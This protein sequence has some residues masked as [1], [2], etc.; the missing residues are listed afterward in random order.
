MSV[1]LSILIIKRSL[2]LMDRYPNLSLPIAVIF[3]AF[4]Y[5]F[6]CYATWIT[7]NTIS[8]YSFGILALDSGSSEFQKPLT[9]QI[10]DILRSFSYVLHKPPTLEFFDPEWSQPGHGVFFYT[11]F[12]IYPTLGFYQSTQLNYHIILSYVSNLLRLILL[13]SFTFWL[14]L[15][16][17]QSATMRLWAR[18]VESE[19]P[20]FTVVFGGAAALAKA[21]ELAF[22]WL[23]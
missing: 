10:G 14:C 17:L 13:A 5:V 9:D 4:Q 20:V 8:G 1:S 19:K 15:R 11:I 16:P 2:K 6:I 18:I 22:K 7:S 3:L 23:T 12:G 21:G